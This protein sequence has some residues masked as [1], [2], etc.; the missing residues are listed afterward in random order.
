MKYKWLPVFDVHN[1][2]G[3]RACVS[4]CASGSLTIVDERVTFKNPEGCLS[5]EWCVREC[6]VGGIHMEWLPVPDSTCVGKVADRAPKM[7][8][9]V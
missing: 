1:C 7:Q 4:Y 5:D 6:P 2:S 9:A 3:C 8:A